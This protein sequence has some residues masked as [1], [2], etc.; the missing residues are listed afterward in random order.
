M[1]IT[2]IVTSV[3]LE[4]RS[5]RKIQESRAANIDVKARMKTTFAVDVLKTASRNV[6]ELMP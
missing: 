5:F 1:A 4:G 2:A 3:A 6:H